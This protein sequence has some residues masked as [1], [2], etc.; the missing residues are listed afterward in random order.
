MGFG[1]LKDCIGQRAQPRLLGNPGVEVG[2]GHGVKPLEAPMRQKVLAGCQRAR[3]SFWHLTRQRRGHIARLP[4][5]V[6][7][8]R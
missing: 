4:Q 5:I 3:V 7:T 1:L 2:V 6:D 8:V